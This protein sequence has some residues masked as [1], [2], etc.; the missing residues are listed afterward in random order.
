M[1]DV[2]FPYDTRFTFESLMF[3]TGED[4][5]LKML[6]PGS[7][8][9]RLTSVY[10]QSP[11][12]STI[13]STIGGACSGLDSYAG[14]YIHTVK[15][16]WGIPIVTSIFQPSVGASSSSLSTTSPIKIQLMITPRSEEVPVGTLLRRAVS[17][18]WCS[19]WRAFTEQLQQISHHRKIRSV[20]CSVAQ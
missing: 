15:L 14:L 17:S 5:H 9:E 7:A 3:A 19:D 8:L 11:Y 4:K 12:F 16:I 6:P 2:M 20:Q 10:G 1:F 18:S 13:S